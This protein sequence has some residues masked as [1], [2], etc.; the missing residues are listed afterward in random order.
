M[1]L[2]KSWK[3]NK[4]VPI[5]AGQN[6]PKH[7]DTVTIKHLKNLKV[8]NINIKS[9]YIKH[10]IEKK[11]FN[12]LIIKCILVYNYTLRNQFGNLKNET[13]FKQS[14]YLFSFLS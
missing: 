8:Q 3:N 4:F 7:W 14:F 2:Y 10:N 13:L 6:R 5:S 12:Q 1:K 9:C 11:S